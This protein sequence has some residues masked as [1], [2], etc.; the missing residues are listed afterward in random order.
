M[1]WSHVYSKELL[2]LPEY[3]QQKS[4]SYKHWKKITPDQNFIYILEDECKKI[5][6]VFRENYDLIINPSIFDYICMKQRYKKED[7]LLFANLNTICLTKICKRLDKR[8]TPCPQ[9]KIWLHQCKTSNR[10][11]F[12]GGMKIQSIT[13]TLPIECPICLELYEKNKNIIIAKCGHYCCISC[14][15]NI[16][17]FKYQNITSPPIIRC[18][19]CRKINPYSNFI[20][21]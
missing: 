8:I 18:P 1:K 7:L 20:I 17:K 19:T 11:D 5:N 21:I 12:L 2:K 16:H 10:Y 4:F 15:K 14:Y 6:T 13:I 9:L 3:F